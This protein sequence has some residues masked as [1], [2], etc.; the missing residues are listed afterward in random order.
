[1]TFFVRNGAIKAFEGSRLAP[2]NLMPT[3]RRSCLFREREGHM[4]KATVLQE[5]ARRFE[6][7]AE[8]AIDPISKRDYKEVAAHYRSLAVEH[9]EFKHDEPA[10]QARQSLSDRPMKD[11][12]DQ[13]WEWATKPTHSDLPIPAEIHTAV[14]RLSPDDRRDRAK[15]NE[16]VWREGPPK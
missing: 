8:A 13:W 15:V 1:V 4:S 7:R 3:F 2:T 16:A 9:L 10:N 14:M 5:K 11:A 12:F 6:Q